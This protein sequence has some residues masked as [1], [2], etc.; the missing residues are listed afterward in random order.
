[1]KLEVITRLLQSPLRAKNVNNSRYS[2]PSFGSKT[3]APIPAT[4]RGRAKRNRL[5]FNKGC[6]NRR[7]QPRV[8]PS[9]NAGFVLVSNLH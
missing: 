2:K 3:H 4:L 6:I 5:G 1:M 9:V 8:G 7:P